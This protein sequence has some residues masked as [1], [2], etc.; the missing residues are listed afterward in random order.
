MKNILRDVTKEIKPSK[1]EEKEIKV[2]V[3]SFLVK[4][5]KRLKN[6]KAV[7]GGSGIK[8]TWLKDSTDFD[9][10]IVFDYKKFKHKSDV[11]S[12]ILEKN[13]KKHYRIA[14]L[15]G[16]RDY[17]QIKN[18]GFTF[19]LIPI[20]NIKK[21]E[22][23]VNIT[24]V[25]LLHAEFVKKNK[26]YCNDIRLMKQFCRANKIY[27]AESYIKGFSGYMCEVLTIYYRGFLHLVK[28][29]SKWKDKEI[30]DIKKYYKARDVLVEMNKSKTYSPLILIDPADKERN[31]AAGLSFEKYTLFITACKKFL[32]KPSREFF[33]VKKFSKEDLIKK[34]K[35]REVVVAEVKPLKGKED[36][37]GAKMLKALEMINAKA[38]KEGFKILDKG[39]EWDKEN[40]AYLYIIA[41]K[42]HLG[43]FK[44]LEGPPLKIRLHACAFKKQHKTTFIKKGKLFAKE[45][46]RFIRAKDFIRN[47]FNDK[48]IKERVG[49]IRLI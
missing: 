24:D 4:L 46:R 27:G 31:A 26:R 20:L 14:R 34:N 22:Q 8:G 41:D 9:I 25:S 47:L 32:A 44:I 3:N 15:H 39:L 33:K 29:V 42:K 7:L 23:A 5:N 2:I 19:E 48:Y 16:S 28:A 35:S 12:D 45:K 1:G 38:I 18:K 43:N 21:A 36:V 49:G 13:I 10:Y 30:I 40:N 37:V 6:C 17:F 11:L